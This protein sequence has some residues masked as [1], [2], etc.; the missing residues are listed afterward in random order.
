MRKVVCFTWECWT[1]HL[2]VQAII[3]NALR[4]RGF[5]P[6]ILVCD[7]LDSGIKACELCDVKGIRDCKRSS[8]QKELFQSIWVFRV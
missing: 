3:L 8:N 7:G 5:E 2:A 4:F 6:V 1:H